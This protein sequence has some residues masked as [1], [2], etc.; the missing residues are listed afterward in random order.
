MKALT[1]SLVA[2]SLFTSLGDARAQ[3]GRPAPRPTPRPFT[4][5][6]PPVVTPRPPTIVTRPGNPIHSPRP[7]SH[8]AFASVG[9]GGDFGA[10]DQTAIL[11]LVASTVGLSNMPQGSLEAASALVSHQASY[12][13]ADVPSSPRSAPTPGNSAPGSSFGGIGW[14]ILGG[15]VLVFAAVIAIVLGRS[16]A[17]TAMGRV[18]IVGTPHGEAPLWVREAWVGLELPVANGQR[19]PCRQPAFGVLS[20]DREDDRTGFAVDG[21]RAVQ[22]L[23]ARCPEAADWWWRNAAH[24]TVGGYQF[25]FPAEVCDEVG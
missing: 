6:P 9:G 11:T 15:V 10:E 20:N 3:F 22:L 8:P 4:P 13:P 2:L 5:R 21:R 14:A 19:G 24:V 1:T 23:A 17:A 16:H 18:R 7:T 25:V 12:T